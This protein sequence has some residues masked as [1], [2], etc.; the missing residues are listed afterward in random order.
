MKSNLAT[1]DQVVNTAVAYE[2][3]EPVKDETAL[4]DIA[5]ERHR[6][7]A[8]LRVV[9]NAARDAAISDDAAR[10]FRGLNQFRIDAKTLKDRLARAGVTPIALLPL[11]AWE[12]LCD[13]AKLYRFRPDQGGQVRI[14]TKAFNDARQAVTAK[15]KTPR[16]RFAFLAVPVMIGLA[17]LSYN[18]GVPLGASV[19]FVGIIGSGFATLFTALVLDSLRDSEQKAPLVG[20]IL[21]SKIDAA[22]K[23][24]SIC[25][26]LW[27]NCCEPGDENSQSWVR[28]VYGIELVSAS[29]RITLPEPPDDVQ[30]TLIAAERGGATLRLAVVGDAISLRE[31]PFDAL[32]AYQKRQ[33]EEEAHIRALDPIVYTVEGAA[34]AVIAQYG[35]FPI[36]QEV[37]NE[38]VNSVYLA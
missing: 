6:Y 36:E 10:L 15:L 25:A 37:V 11:A 3:G 28:R 1:L 18:H 31:D 12:R 4:A 30:K 20:S 24:G 14:S 23:D 26:L 5:P 32:M 38:V 17:V 21:R 33:L 22:K 35:D 29:V 16:I 27:P 19:G 7:V 9:S 2:L 13:R 8:G 34:V